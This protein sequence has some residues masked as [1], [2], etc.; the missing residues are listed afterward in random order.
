[1]SNVATDTL[2]ARVHDIQETAEML[3]VFQSHGHN[4]VDTARIYGAGSSEEALTAAEWQ[5]RRLAMATKL[6]PS[7]AAVA[8]GYTHQP[9]DLRRGL[10]K[11]LSALSAER[12]DLFYLHGPDRKTPVDTLREVNRRRTMGLWN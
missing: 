4:E 9:E 6:Y 7:T 11:S 1:M 10:L 3:N 12:L 8:E 5:K 2:G